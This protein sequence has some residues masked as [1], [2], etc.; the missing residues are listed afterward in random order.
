MKAAEYI[1][2][3]KYKQQYIA[4]DDLNAV[5]KNA[6]SKQC[7]DLFEAE[8]DS[9]NPRPTFLRRIHSRLNKARADE[10]RKE[11]NNLVK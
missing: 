1:M 11:I 2:A 8:K 6:T 4:W 7:L 3:N 9:K 10:E 5:L